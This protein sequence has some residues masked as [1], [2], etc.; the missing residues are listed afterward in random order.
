VK[1]PFI[2]PVC[3]WLNSHDVDCP[4]PGS[5][6]E[7]RRAFSAAWDDFATVAGRIIFAPIVN[8]MTRGLR[9]LGGRKP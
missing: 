3:G 9:R 4:Y 6:W 5:F 1:V 8:A 7:A 2:C